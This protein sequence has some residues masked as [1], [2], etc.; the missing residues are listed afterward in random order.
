M[1]RDYVISK[2]P[3]HRDMFGGSER[4]LQIVGTESSIKD[5]VLVLR[6]V[7]SHGKSEPLSN[8]EQDVLCD[9]YN[10]LSI[11]NFK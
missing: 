1:A 11:F 2:L 6:S 5:L 10:S 3:Y 4:T 7:L 9:L 8:Y